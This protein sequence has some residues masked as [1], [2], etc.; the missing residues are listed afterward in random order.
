[1]PAPINEVYRRWTD[2]PRFSE[3][4]SN[5]EQVTP[6]GDNRYHWL[7]RIFGV[8]QEWDAEVTDNDPNRRVAWRSLTGAH[9]AGTVTF[10][11][12][13]GGRT[14]VR[15]RLEYAPPGGKVGQAL[16]QLTNTTRKELREDLQ[17]FTKLYTGGQPGPSAIRSAAQ[18]IAQRAR[19][20][21][22]G[23]PQQLPQQMQGGLGSVLGPLAAPVTVA[24]AGGV[25]SYMIG[26][27]LRQSR[28]YAM[29][30][31]PVALPNA[32]AGWA[33]TGASAASVLGSAMLRSRGRMTDALFVGQ[34]APTFLGMGIG[35]RL[36]GHRSVNTN[37][38]TSVTSWTYFSASLGSIAASAFLHLRGRREDGLFV[39]QWAPTFL[40]AAL[41][42]RLFNRLITR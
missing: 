15:V 28:R 6:R 18:G 30:T 1:V 7:A 23:L 36:L 21:V 10:T 42:T 37:L 31:N 41:F 8:K 9:N 13:G 35:T 32:V 4:M 40:N 27:R 12:L 2:F 33:L 26:K 16:D 17:N 5:V 11:D 34:W 20:Q 39:G 24:A 14:Q 3:F 19:G 22:Y 25:A 38:P 29:A